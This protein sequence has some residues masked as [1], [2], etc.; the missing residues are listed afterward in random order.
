MRRKADDKN[1][2]LFEYV[3]ETIEVTTPRI[4]IMENVRSLV[5]CEKGA[6]WQSFSSQLDDMTKAVD[7]ELRIEGIRL[8][9][10]E[11]G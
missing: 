7:R 11:K 2:D 8:V 9:H 6:I 5:T 3:L 4:V 1:R 10:K